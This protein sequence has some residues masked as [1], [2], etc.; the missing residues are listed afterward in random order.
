MLPGPATERKL[1]RE[2]APYSP[3]FLAAY[4]LY[5]QA[6]LTA[7]AMESAQMMRTAATEM[8]TLVMK[9]QSSAEAFFFLDVIY[10][11]LGDATKRQAA[12]DRM[13][14]LG[15][16]IDFKV[17]TEVV[18]PEELA[19]LQTRTVGTA[20]IAGTP[21]P[22][23][24]GT[25]PVVLPGNLNPA[26]NTVLPNGVVAPLP[27]KYALVIGQSQSRV[28]GGLVPF[29][30]TD[31][32]RVHDALVNFAGYLPENVVMIQNTTA[33][34]I[35]TAATAL[36]ARAGEGAT[37]V[38]FYAGAGVNLGGKD[39]LAGVDTES[40][41]DTSSMYGKAELLSTFAQRGARVFAF[42]EASRPIDANGF[43]FGREVITGGSIA[44][45]QAT[46]PNDTVGATYRDNQQVGLFANAFVQTLSELRSNR[47]P[48]FEFTWQVFYA[49]RRGTSGTTGGGGTQVCTLPQLTNL[50]AD[51]KF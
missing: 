1:W 23:A 34:E 21:T 36:A 32:Q 18:A 48:I 9:D 13:T 15:R 40:T 39:Y 8:E 10:T 28:S 2:G 7:D 45:V 26:T 11:K 19:A 20:G 4:S 46:R 35:K 30:T 12:A 17:D 22:T 3:N 31:V 43:Y 44:Q 33:A 14:K 41:S 6:L 38:I 24:P 29:A 51:A 27:D 25:S 50:A 42:F 47:L 49:M 5:R 37:V 16:K